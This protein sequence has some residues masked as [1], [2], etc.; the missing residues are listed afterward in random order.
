MVGSRDFLMP[1]YTQG[2]FLLPDLLFDAS[3]NF[4]KYLSFHTVDSFM[5]MLHFE[6]IALQHSL[7]HF[8]F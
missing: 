6:E 8:P 4:S 2:D 7:H 5:L 3:F 1:V